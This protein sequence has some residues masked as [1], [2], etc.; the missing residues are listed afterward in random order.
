MPDSFNMHS[1][2]LKSDFN[3]ELPEDRIAS[4]PLTQRD[5]SKL[6]FYD[7]GIINHYS[8]SQIPDLLPRN[9]TLVFN[10]TK[11][12]RA[13]LYFRRQTGAMIEILL[14]HPHKPKEVQ[15]AMQA[16]GNCIWECMIGNKKKWKED[17]ILTG[18]FV[19]YE[20]LVE[21]YASFSDRE[22]QLVQLTWNRDLSFAEL[23]KG[24]G[25]IPLP[26]YLN[27]QATEADIYQYQTIYARHEGA[28]AAPTAGLHFT[29]AVMQSLNKR[30]IKREYVTLHV[31]AGTFLP[32]KT[33]S[34]AQHHM[35][36]E[37]LI[38][39]RANIQFFMEYTGPIIPVGTTSMRVLES[40]YWL[41]V[42][43]LEKQQLQDHFF[44][45]PQ[46][47]PYQF[48]QQDLPTKKQSLSAILAYMQHHD[49]AQLIGETSI[50]IM[51]GYTFQMCQGIITNFHMPES[52][53]IMLIAALI[54][55][56]WRK[57]YESSLEND[58]RFLS[59]GDSSLLLPK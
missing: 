59:Y 52:T 13:R 57:V 15:L 23:I 33:Q 37:Q 6:L 1:S 55:D 48:M 39:T 31:G 54:G 25:E 10:N 19:L 43:L 38:L 28:V 45:I 51:P 29:D 30:K 14:L 5:N 20:K 21:V 50:F 8:F 26:P 4:R 18:K 41:G 36:S 3:Y 40:M 47:Y 53:L 12:I 49:L 35:H 27:R 17:E 58:Y 2:L 7:Q 56:D 24:I 42:Q 34:I 16:K 46:A 22:K 32:V 11:V 44:H 9:S